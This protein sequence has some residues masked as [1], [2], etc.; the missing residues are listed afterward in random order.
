MIDF[1]TFQAVGFVVVAALWLLLLT[2][3]FRWMWK[4]VY[5]LKRPL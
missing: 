5:K 2:S 4:G 1:E 3:F